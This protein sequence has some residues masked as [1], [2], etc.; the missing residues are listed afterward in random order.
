M[1]LAYQIVLVRNNH[2]GDLWKKKCLTVILP[3][4]SDFTSAMAAPNLSAIMLKK[5]ENKHII[6]EVTNH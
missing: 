6:T 5:K 4:M 3:P 1:C 2:V